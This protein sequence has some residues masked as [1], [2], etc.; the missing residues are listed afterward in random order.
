MSKESIA[1]TT[2]DQYCWCYGIVAPLHDQL[3]ERKCES[4]T[5]W[6]QRCEKLMVRLANGG[7]AAG[8]VVIIKNSLSF[9]AKLAFSQ[10]LA[11]RQSTV[12]LTRA[13]KKRRKPRPTPEGIWDP[14][15]VIQFYLNAKENTEMELEELNTKG[16]LLV[17]LYTACR[18]GELATVDMGN[19]HWKERSLELSLTT[20]TSQAGTFLTIYKLEVSKKKVCAF[21]LIKFL[22]DKAQQVNK[23]AG[24]FLLNRKGVRLNRNA[25]YNRLRKG[26]RRAGV[27][28]EFRPYMIKHA[29]LTYLVRRGVNFADASKFARLSSNQET[30]YKH[31]YRSNRGSDLTKM[32]SEAGPQ[33]G[34][35][36]QEEDDSEPYLEL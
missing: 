27:P 10:K 22:W 15:I 23:D 20:K 7:R 4:F 6:G 13:L 1:P 33:R 35:D 18:P 25:I 31:Y 30:V 28:A 3:F 14:E 19:S 34:S 29:A 11:E 2:W 5:E 16:I 21:S 12:L 36:Q 9:I 32:I 8:S 24:S 17:C 26:L